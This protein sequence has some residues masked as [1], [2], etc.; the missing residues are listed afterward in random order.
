MQLLKLIKT[1][2]LKRKGQKNKNLAPV[3]PL[4]LLTD[5]MAIAFF[6]AIR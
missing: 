1:L 4:G 5:I 3:L 2:V 6:L